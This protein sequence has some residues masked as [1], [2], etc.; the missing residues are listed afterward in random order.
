MYIYT[1]RCYIIAKPVLFGN[2]NIHVTSAK[3]GTLVI[4]VSVHA[5]EYNYTFTCMYVY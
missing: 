2:H 4:E 5:F 3:L 1:H